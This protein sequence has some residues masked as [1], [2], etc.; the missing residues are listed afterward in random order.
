MLREHLSFFY[1]K[2]DPFLW[3]R[4]PFT[5]GFCMR[6]KL[7]LSHV[8]VTITKHVDLS[9]LCFPSLIVSGIFN[10]GKVAFLWSQ[11]ERGSAVT[12][13]AA[14]SLY[15]CPQT[16]SSSTLRSESGPLFSSL[17]LGECL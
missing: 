14:R 13:T 15:L 11:H 9:V 1:L 6:R 12:V 7:R 2:T 3:G 10:L 4:S 16:S 5:F 17:G 8:L